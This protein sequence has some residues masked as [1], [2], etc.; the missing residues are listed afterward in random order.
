MSPRE[1][2]SVMRLQV[3][4]TLGTSQ[5]RNQTDRDVARSLLFSRVRVSIIS[6][7]S[8]TSRCSFRTFVFAR[9]ISSSRSSIACRSCFAR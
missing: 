8:S 6:C 7:L 5:H 2:L 1:P 3:R 4:D 9:L